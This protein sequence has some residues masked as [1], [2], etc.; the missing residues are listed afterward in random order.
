MRNTILTT[1]DYLLLLVASFWLWSS[2]TFGV[3]WMIWCVVAVVF[4]TRSSSWCW[5]LLVG[6]PCGAFA[7]RTPSH[8]A[9]KVGV[10]NISLG[11]SYG[12][13]S[14]G[15]EELFSRRSAVSAACVSPEQA[16]F[17]K[18]KKWKWCET[19]SL[20]GLRVV[21]ICGEERG[22]TSKIHVK[23]TRSS[24]LTHAQVAYI[25]LCTN[26]WNRRKKW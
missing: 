12:I 2:S 5:I 9:C 15:Q 19:L 8:S 21:W 23:T 3:L 20:P 10:L 11:H 16:F 24:I 14:G 18:K 13:A 22:K 26:V 4:A 25:T 17:F 7:P 6:G 1:Y